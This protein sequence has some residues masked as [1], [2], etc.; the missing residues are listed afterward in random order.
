[1]KTDYSEITNK[2]GEPLWWDEKGVPRYE[3]FENHYQCGVYNKAVA[4]LRIECQNCRKSFFVT[5]VIAYN[6]GFS[7][8]VQKRLERIKNLLSEEMVSHEN[9]QKA[10]NEHEEDFY[11]IERPKLNNVGDFYYKDPPNHGCIGD[12][13]GSIEREVLQYWE[14][15]LTT[16][17]DSTE[18]NL[19]NP[20]DIKVISDDW[21][22]SPKHEIDVTPTW[23]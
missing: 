16:T 13:M 8:F 23:W 18:N 11:Q 1:M 3:P 10:F 5:S 22:R 12:T 20:I 7:Q 2:L 21:I 4:Y 19:G 15:D 9:L 17:K 14:P 6:A